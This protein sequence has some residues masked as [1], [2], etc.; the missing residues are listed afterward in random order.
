MFQHNI[1]W[2]EF[3]RIERT[4]IQIRIAI[5]AA[6][7]LVW[8]G[9]S[10]AQDQLQIPQIPRNNDP[11]SQPYFQHLKTDY[12]RVPSQLQGPSVSVTDSER[13]SF[14]AQRLVAKTQENLDKAAAKAAEAETKSKAMLAAKAKADQMRADARAKEKA[15][16][17]AQV[18]AAQMRADAKAK[19]NRKHSTGGGSQS[20]DEVESS[21]DKLDSSETANE[22]KLPAPR[23]SRGEGSGM[24]APRPVVEELPA[25]KRSMGEGSGTKDDGGKSKPRSDVEE[26]PAPTPDPIADPNT[27]Q[28]ILAAP[29]QHTPNPYGHNADTAWLEFN[30]GIS[31]NP[32]GIVQNPGMNNMTFGHPVVLP[33]QQ[34]VPYQQPITNV[35]PRIRCGSIACDVVGG[36]NQPGGCRS[37]GHRGPI[38]AAIHHRTHAPIRNII[39]HSVCGSPGCAQAGGCDQ[40]GGCGKIGR[41]QTR[42]RDRL[43]NSHLNRDTCDPG[44]LLVW[45]SQGARTSPRHR[46]PPLSAPIVTDRPSFTPSSSVVG[47]GVFQAELGYTY[48]FNDDVPGSIR[49]HSSPETLFRY[50]FL[51]D[52]LELRI[53]WNHLDQ[54]INDVDYEGS[55]DLTLGVKIGLAAQAGIRP[56]MALI[57][58]LSLPTGNDFF[59]KGEVLPGLGLVYGW[60]LGSRLRASGSTQFDRDVDPSTQKSFTLWSQSIMFRYRLNDRAAAYAE[61]FGL[62]PHSADYVDPE[63]FFN[64]GLTFLISNNVQWD[65]RYGFNFDD[66]NGHSFD[67]YFAG[68]GLSF[69]LR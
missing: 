54:E 4:V 24:R 23:K 53:A 34:V 31:A 38:G 7:L 28:G 6:L 13:W 40:A 29:Q 49:T 63:H 44:A 8:V 58:R 9:L 1:R 36:C 10:H 50:G 66:K 14:D 17:A 33:A 46:I 32:H 15:K 65:I 21:S 61:Y 41:P 22:P 57:H 35:A 64:T 45:R 48:L 62:Y 39:H 43:E 20:E 5:V 69:R 68:M 12:A 18:K 60:N 16:I 52:W 26:I 56:E 19:Q 47:L 42:I 67:N 59:S 11:L 55:E 3:A 51:R 37:V 25:P 2:L 27:N 30:Q